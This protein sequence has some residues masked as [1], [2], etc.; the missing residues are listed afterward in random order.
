MSDEI[1]VTITLP[2]EDLEPFQQ[3]A[4]RINVPLKTIL[5]Q[6]I[7]RHRVDPLFLYERCEQLIDPTEVSCL[8]VAPVEV[9]EME[10]RVLVFVAKQY[11]E[12]L[13]L[14]KNH[15]T[16]FLAASKD[17]DFGSSVDWREEERSAVL[18]H[19]IAKGTIVAEQVGACLRVEDSK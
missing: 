18:A 5:S 14:G 4:D 7:M 19:A 8:A 9:A 1:N 15:H 16:A 17:F 6:G 13:L 10:R 12:D 11:A 3:I 2:K